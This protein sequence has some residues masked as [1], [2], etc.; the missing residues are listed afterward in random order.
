MD[1]FQL[2]TAALFLRR[3]IENAL[4]RGDLREAQAMSRRL[5][6]MTLRCL[7]AEQACAPVK[8]TAGKA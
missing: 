3:W 2:R 4:D 7:E 6:E 5:D 8:A 1:E